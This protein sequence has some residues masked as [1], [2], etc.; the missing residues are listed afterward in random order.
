MPDLLDIHRD[1]FNRLTDQVR[2]LEAEIAENE[3][4]AA[5]DEQTAS[6]ELLQGQLDQVV[7]RIEAARARADRMHAGAELLTGTP[8]VGSALDRVRTTHVELSEFQTWGEYA[9]ALANGDVSPVAATAI[10]RM[11]VSLEGEARGRVIEGSR[12]LVDQTTANLA[13]ILPP[14]WLTDIVDFY[15]IM[16]PLIS[17]FST[18]PLPASGLTVNFPQVTVRPLVAKQTTEKGA[19]PSRATTIVAGSAAVSTYGGGEDVSVQAIQRTD[20]AY[21]AIVN[22][23]YAEQAAIVM[24]TDACTTVISAVPAG[25][26]NNLTLSLATNGSDINKAL[27]TAGKTILNARANFDT[28]VMG[29]DLWAY[30]VGAADTTGRPLF[31]T[32][33][34]VNP[35]GQSAVNAATGNARG[36]AFV[37]DPNMAPANGV[38]GDSRAFTTML[39]GLQTLQANNPAQIGIDFAVFEFAAFA[40]RRPS[41]LVKFTLGA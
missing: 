39:G 7:P 4:G 11:I 32:V 30:V 23:L 13:G 27:A 40:V 19:V 20:P 35:V 18:R 12:A 33:G 29:T 25:A 15:G 10:D 24:D 6:L 37:A 28:F 3:D 16:R 26:N 8:N 36:V 31:P 34:P 17:A 22:E 21:L 14:S 38:A 2:A 9:R 1:T 5:S 41:A